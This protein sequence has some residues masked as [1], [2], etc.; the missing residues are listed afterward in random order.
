MP[1]NYNDRAVSQELADQLA[2]EEQNANMMGQSMFPQ[3]VPQAG[4]PLGDFLS[5]LHF[6]GQSERAQQLAEANGIPTA[7][8]NSFVTQ[9]DQDTAHR[10][11]GLIRAV[12]NIGNYTAEHPAI[13]LAPLAAAAAMGG[14]GAG[15]GGG[16]LSSIGGGGATG[17]GGL[18]NLVGQ[19]WQ[20]LG[21]VSGTIPAATTAATTA[22]APAAS[23]TGWLSSILGGGGG[24]GGS[25]LMS[26]LSLGAKGAGALSQ[27][28][29]EGSSAQRLASGVSDVGNIVD[30]VSGGVPSGGGGGGGGNGIWSGIK[31]F[32]TNSDTGNPA[33]GRIAGA[34][35]GALGLLSGMG[36]EQPASGSPGLPSGWSDSLPPRTLTRERIPLD[37]A[38]YATYGKS[39]G[40]HKF[41]GDAEYHAGG[42]EVSGP[43]TGRS[44]DIE[45]YLSNGEYVMD[46]E[47][48]ALLG[49]GSTEAGAKRLDELRQRVRQ[50]KGA[51]L[52]KGEFS[53]D[54]KDPADYMAKGGKVSSALKT[55]PPVK[56]PRNEADALRALVDTMRIQKLEKE[57]GGYDPYNRP[58]PR[59]AKGGRVP[60]RTGHFD[61]ILKDMR[62]KRAITDEIKQKM[63][64]AHPGLENEEKGVPSIGPKGRFDFFSSHRAD[65][66][67]L[68]RRL[69]EKIKP[70]KAKGGRIRGDWVRRVITGGS[71]TPKSPELPEFREQR[72][73]ALQRMVR[74]MKAAQPPTEEPKP[75]L[76]VVKARGG[77]IESRTRLDGIKQFAKDTPVKKAE[78]GPVGELSKFADRLEEALKVGEPAHLAR[79]DTESSAML[80][81]FTAEYAKGGVVKAEKLS[82]ILEKIKISQRSP[83]DLRKIAEELRQLNP[84]SD[85]LRQ[86]EFAD[87]RKVSRE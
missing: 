87:R 73:E 81:T 33:W 74:D 71:E 82:P 43:G 32:F 41:F 56:A 72:L 62:E 53:P 85:I 3:G 84:N 36:H 46:A 5:N 24:A 42:G 21:S 35:A 76:R 68:V 17:G 4:D 11:P 1:G 29:P 25:S 23:S 26:N 37:P 45:A 8:W 65:L 66:D 6:S 27:V 39:G 7:D 52:A 14:F 40:E 67:D 34:G 49:D 30:M 58:P 44:D 2:A 38:A 75:K 69:A 64:D 70:K 55:L 86:Y 80:P 31:N 20:S 50:H 47:T 12:G 59:K 60:P 18:G 83:D 54:A 61:A 10:A 48:V 79:L 16:G 13:L 15:A 57:S 22:A 78:G 9:R 28:L 63:Y 77:L 51:A 19:G